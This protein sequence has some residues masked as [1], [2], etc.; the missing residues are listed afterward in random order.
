MGK[1]PEY[2]PIRE[3][4]YLIRRGLAE[5]EYDNVLRFVSSKF[6]ALSL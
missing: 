5:A 1:P 6:P 2:D 4:E 3:T